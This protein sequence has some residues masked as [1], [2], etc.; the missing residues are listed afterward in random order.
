M[1]DAPRAREFV[2]A[3]EVRVPR[4]KQ[5]AVALRDREV[6]RQERQPEARGQLQARVPRAAVC[7]RGDGVQVDGALAGGGDGEGGLVEQHDAVGVGLAGYHRG[8]DGA[9]LEDVHVHDCCDGQRGVCL[10][11]PEQ[12]VLASGEVVLVRDVELGPADCGDGVWDGDK[13]VNERADM[14]GS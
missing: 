14:C 1:T 8:V 4:D 13:W 10:D 5:S 12:G 2:Q 11:G 3:R 7:R 9:V 6:V